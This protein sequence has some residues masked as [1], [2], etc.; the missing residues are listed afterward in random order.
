[1]DIIISPELCIERNTRIERNTLASHASAP[2]IEL[3]EQQTFYND[4]HYWI[5]ANLL[6]HQIRLFTLLYKYHFRA[7][8]C[9]KDTL[10][11]YRMLLFDRNSVSETCI[12]DYYDDVSACTRHS[13]TD[14]SKELSL[15][16]F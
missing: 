2:T 12:D 6:R 14:S 4:I 7:W 16:D 13:S 9:F 3:Y 5:V 15:Q 8:S 11:T 10:Y 1:M